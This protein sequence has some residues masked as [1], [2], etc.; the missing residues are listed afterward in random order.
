MPKC[1]ILSGAPLSGKSTW[2]KKQ[3]L[4]ILSCDR[5]RLEYFGGKYK[6]DPQAEKEIWE[7]FYQRVGLFTKDFIVD[8]TNCKQ[9]YINKIKENIIGDYEIEI[10]KFEVNLLKSYYRNIKRW[11]FENKFIPFKIIKKF[12]KDYKKLWNIK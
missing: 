11:A 5:L 1:I 8:N 12:K 4:P 3:K 2:A 6:F 9:S 7:D 10:V